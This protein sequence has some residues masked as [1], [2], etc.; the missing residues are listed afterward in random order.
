MK[1][2]LRVPF[3]IL[4]CVAVVAPANSQV[5]VQIGV[6]F[7]GDAY[8]VVSQALPPDSNG[9]IGPGRYVEFINGVVSVYNR[10][11]GLRMQRK[12]DLKFW[13]DAG[14]NVSAVAVS[15]PR[16][17]YDPT[18]QR[19]FATQVDFDP[20][21]ADPSA[22][23]N[24]FLLAVSTTSSPTDPWKAFSIPSDPDQGFFA[25][26]PT[27]GLDG[28]AVY[29]SGDFYSEGETPE[30]P[31]LLSIPKA[32]L[33]AATPTI[34][35]RTWYGVMDYG[36]RGDV[37]QPAICFDGS[38]HGSILAMGDIGTDSSP[39]SNVVW[40]AVENAGG[41]GATLSPPVNLTVDPYEVPDN[42]LLGVPQFVATQTDGTSVL[43]ANDARLSAKVYAVGGVLYAVHSTQ[44]NGRIAIRWYRIR[45][46]DQTLL[47]QGTIADPNLDL[48]F[49][50]IA[51]NPFGTVMICCN[52][53]GLG[54]YISCYAYAGQTVNGQTT[55]GDSLL[56]KAGVA[57]YHDLNEILGDLLDTP[58][59]SR[60]GDYSAVSVDPEDPTQFWTIQM[61][62]S[63]VD[64]LLD[65]GVWSTQ[66]TQ[67]I[68]TTPPTLTI[69][70]SG[71][72]AVVSWPLAAS[73]YQPFSTTNLT[74]PVVWSGVSQNSITNGSQISVTVPLE[75]AGG[76]FRLQ[77]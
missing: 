69:A 37:L 10:T 27:L 22:T 30:G 15:D 52:G 36:V 43:Q 16:V 44:L 64:P 19:W 67:L 29:I 23:A 56:L 51:A 21:A 20:N 5:S 75:G 9:E 68:V 61:F 74:P 48:F 40:F 71:V 55:F 54:N 49:P 50:S 62:P 12:S 58:T 31:G 14:L 39:H 42:D 45:A 13:A 77:K 2:C 57:D 17:I 59:T 18:V 34:A 76:F 24:D 8:G 1:Y 65:S 7:T 46:S 63:D 38:A 32:D 3:A 4:F 47:E 66:I 53:S 26:F 25:D 60:W 73:G 33:I 41:T 72:N 70:T 6:N 28:D 11:N 35:N